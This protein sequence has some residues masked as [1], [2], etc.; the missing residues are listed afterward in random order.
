MSAIKDLSS[1]LAS[2][3]GI[4]FSIQLQNKNTTQDTENYTNALELKDYIKVSVKSE[5]AGTVQPTDDKTY[6]WR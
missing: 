4:Q 2:S 1:I 5:N 3:N 6:T